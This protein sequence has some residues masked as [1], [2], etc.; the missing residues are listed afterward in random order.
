LVIFSLS[1]KG[2]TGKT[3]VG[4]GVAS[5]LGALGRKTLLIDADCGLRSVDIILGVSDKAVMHLGDVLAGNV[6]WED[7]VVTHPDIPNLSIL[8]APADESEFDTEKLRELTAELSEVYDIVWIDGSAGLGDKHIAVAN[9]ADVAVLVVTPDIVSMRDAARI[10]ELLD[11]HKRIRLVVNR[12]RP[13]LVMSK[14]ALDIDDVMDGTGAPLLG[15]VPED[16]RVIAATNNGIPLITV[17]QDGAA[18]AYR[19]IALRITGERIPQGDI[20]MVS[21]AKR[22]FLKEAK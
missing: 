19:D 14:A 11:G 13:R 15:I 9:M 17:S 8:A 20:K 1:G 12:V 22:R 3:S 10:T 18:A 5:C 7:A 4:A 16:E 6:K 21:R 2:G